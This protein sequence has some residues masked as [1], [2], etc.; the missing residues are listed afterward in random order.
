MSV[1]SLSLSFTWGSVKLC[2]WLVLATVESQL[3]FCQQVS[4]Q[5]NDFSFTWSTFL[6]KSLLHQQLR[7]C[8]RT[9]VSWSLWLDSGVVR[10]VR[11]CMDIC[12]CFTEPTVNS[13]H[14][15]VMWWTRIR[16]SLGGESGAVSLFTNTANKAGL[17]AGRGTKSLCQVTHHCL[18]LPFQLQLCGWLY[19]ITESPH[20]STYFA[21]D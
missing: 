17:S 15:E 16:W 7:C 13:H 6:K 4:C 12:A 10:R 2:F 18:A 3:T 19:I 14:W 1:A 5:W 9:S 11:V 21:L 8:S 20:S